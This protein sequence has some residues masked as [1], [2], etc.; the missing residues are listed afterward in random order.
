MI[1]ET[2][3]EYFYAHCRGVRTR[4][5]ATLRY[6]IGEEVYLVAGE[7]LGMDGARMPAWTE[8]PGPTRFETVEE[9]REYVK[10]L[11][12]SMYGFDVIEESIEIM[13]RMTNVVTI[14]TEKVAE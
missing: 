12:K 4:A 7:W 8:H 10:H 9:A 2:T 11:P 3:T 5:D 13:R 14:V 6:D 1:T